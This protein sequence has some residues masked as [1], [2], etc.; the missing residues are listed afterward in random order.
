MPL[1]DLIPWLWAG[2]AAVAGLRARGVGG[3]RWLPAAIGALLLA[4][5]HLWGW[6]KP[7]YFA[8]KNTLIW[9]GVYDSRLWFKFA[10]GL[11]FFPVAGW[12]CW[13]GWRLAARQS[14]LQRLALVAMVLDA[15]YITIRT[16]SVDGWMPDVIDDEPGKSR[17]GCALAGVALLAAVVARPRAEVADAGD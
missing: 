6:N 7:I 2:A 11:V 8:G 14:P 1:A 16:L 3:R 15:L 17:L 9:L 13:R 12:L 5:L 4:S 10:I